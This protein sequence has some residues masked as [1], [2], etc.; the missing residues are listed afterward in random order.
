VLY[1]LLTERCPFEAE[2]LPELCLKI[3]REAHRPISELRPELAADL[4]AV[5]ERCLQKDPAQR[6]AHAAEL[7]SAL[8]PF[9]PAHASADA[10]SARRVIQS[11][12]ATMAEGAPATDSSP[13]PP[14]RRRS[15]TL[16][17]VVAGA[18]IVGG[19]LF[20]TRPPVGPPRLA[21][22]AVDA[23]RSASFLEQEPQAQQEPTPETLAPLPAA[24]LPPAA[25]GPTPTIAPPPRPMMMR[26]SRHASPASRGD[27]DIPAYR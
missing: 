8:E 26:H 19:V 2:S 16:A 21:L 12:G 4:V 24:A 27:D 9:A 11:L 3:S 22:A 17:A 13:V 1:E 6:Y 5:L 23:V 10:S 18:A 7:A 14:R 15:T 25:S 20:A